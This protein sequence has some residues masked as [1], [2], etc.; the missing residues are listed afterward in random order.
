MCGHVSL[1]RSRGYCSCISALDP[2]PNPRAVIL[3]AVRGPVH[4]LAL[5]L[6]LGCGVGF[7]NRQAGT[8]LGCCGRWVSNLVLIVGV[9]PHARDEERIEAFGGP[10]AAA[11]PRGAR[12][13]SPVRRQHQNVLNPWPLGLGLALSP[14][15]TNQMQ[16]WA[17]PLSTMLGARR[18]T[19]SQRDRDASTSRPT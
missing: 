13:S 14:I 6:V 5:E 16:R 18:F 2:P 15:A 8:S 7:G 17:A 19:T 9:Q 4:L 10:V 11:P 1:G 3:T 12:A